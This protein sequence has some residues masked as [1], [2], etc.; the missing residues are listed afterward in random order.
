MAGEPA[1][2]DAGSLQARRSGDWKSGKE[3]TLASP[4]RALPPEA[5]IFGQTQRMARLRAQMALGMRVQ[6]PILIQGES[7]TGKEIVARF[8]A[9]GA[10]RPDRFVKVNCPAIPAAL[11]ESEL[12]GYEKG[13]F[14]GA[15]STKRGRV[16][17][18]DHGLLFLDEIGD[19]DMAVQAKLMQLLQDGTYYRIGGQQERQVNLRVISATNRDLKEQVAR[20]QFRADLFHR[21]NTFTLSLPALRDRILDLPALTDYFLQEYSRTFNRQ[22][23]SLSA[24]TLRVMQHYS[25]PG[26]IRELENLVRRY[27]MLEDEEAILAEILEPL[28]ETRF[29]AKVEINAGLPLKEATRRATRELERQ[30]ILRVLQ[31]N[32]WNRKRTAKTLGI[33]YRGLLYKMR[34]SGFPRITRAEPAQKK[35]QED[36]GE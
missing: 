9:A 28:P 4:E 35:P 13:A 10:T 15:H 31:V 34:E 3:A 29:V 18:A 7:G 19:L 1:V 17:A 20:G 27:V 8:I 23:R 32:N 6:I 30:L 24:E 16:E 5:I 36:S 33:S 25:W 2:P 11:V 22:V 14:T 26:N 21:I 12:F